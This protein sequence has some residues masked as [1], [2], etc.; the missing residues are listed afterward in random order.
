MPLRASEGLEETPVKW[1]SGGGTSVVR[2]QTRGWGNSPDPEIAPVFVLNPNPRTCLSSTAW[3]AV[4]VLFSTLSLIT[5][6]QTG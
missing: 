6:F 3:G 4:L 2:H 1:T 5:P